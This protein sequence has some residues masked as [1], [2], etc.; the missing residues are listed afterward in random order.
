MG[1]TPG[2]AHKIVLRRG[3]HLCTAFTRARLLAD[4]EKIRFWIPGPEGLTTIG[5]SLITQLAEMDGLEF[6]GMDLHSLRFS[7]IH[8]KL[9]PWEEVEEAVVAAF[10]H[11]LGGEVTVIRERRDH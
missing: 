6:G 9:W 5:L 8:P 1:T 10:R 7:T 11:A 2:V 4:S 3:P